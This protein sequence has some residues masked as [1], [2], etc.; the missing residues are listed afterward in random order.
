MEGSLPAR[1]LDCQASKPGSLCK[2]NGPRQNAQYSVAI[3]ESS[4]RAC[5]WVGQGSA[6][7][8]LN[9]SPLAFC[10]NSKQV[11]ER[12]TAL[13]RMFRNRNGAR[14]GGTKECDGA[15]RETSE[16]VPVKKRGGG[17]C[18]TTGTESRK[19]LR[20]QLCAVIDCLLEKGVGAQ[21][22]FA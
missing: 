14:R 16:G 11:E 6:F 1:T 19:A 22:A 13:G 3:I 5:R 4:M 17:E 10:R 7:K 8:S 9:R 2:G 18:R 15:W 12:F 20:A 21:S